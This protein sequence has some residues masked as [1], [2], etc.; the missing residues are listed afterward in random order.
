VYPQ[1]H[2]IDAT[3]GALR[4]FHLVTFA[5]KPNGRG[6]R[7]ARHAVRKHL[8]AGPCVIVTTEL[9]EHDAEPIFG[10]D[11]CIRS[12]A[13]RRLTRL[14]VAAL[15]QAPESG[16]EQQ[17]KLTLGEVARPPKTVLIWTRQSWKDTKSR[18][19]IPRQ[20]WSALT[21]GA[22]PLQD[23]HLDDRIV[24]AIEYC[25][26]SKHPFADRWIADTIRSDR[27]VE[28]LTSNPNRVTRRAAEIDHV[29]AQLSMRG[30]TWWSQGARF[31]SLASKDWY[32][33]EGHLPD[34]RGQVEL[35]A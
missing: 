29:L 27:S 9:F 18:T 15:C 19:S 23:L 12:Q 33:V 8:R 6:L 31:G 4:N 21:S 24:V 26:S 34:V 22:K 17:V 7:E 10:V 32:M 28:L 14:V 1:V 16:I 25:S 11:G 3:L 13:V 5:E 35:G 30:G 20:V 2:I